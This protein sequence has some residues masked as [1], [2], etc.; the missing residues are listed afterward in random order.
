MKARDILVT[1]FPSFVARRLVQT[2]LTHEPDSTVRLLVRPDYVDAAARHLTELKVDR[3]RVKLMSGDVVALDLGLS[4]GEYLDLVAHVTDIYHIASIWYLG[5]DPKQ[6]H[7]VNVLG[8]KNVLDAAHE[9]K[10]LERLNHFST[11]LVAGDRGGVIMEDELEAGQGFRNPYEA[12]KYEAEQWMRRA[13]QTLPISVYRPTVIVGDSVTGEIDKMAGP[14]YL[15]YAIMRAPANMPIVLPGR[16]EKPLNL[17]PIDHVCEAM[18]TISRAD[19]CAGKT[20]HICD[21]NPL[22]ARKVFEMVAEQAGKPAPIGGAPIRLARLAMRLPYVERFVRGQRQFLEELYQLTI[23]NS[24]N[25]TAALAGAVPCPAL[26]DYLPN[27]V[28]HIRRSEPM[29]DI[30][31]PAI[32]DIFG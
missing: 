16:G 32:M 15:M 8:A 1:G 12:T 31:M 18:Y 10:K 30:E 13:M 21:P 26:P 11:A 4:G 7:Q 5:V 14:Y 27:L 2:I 17:V 3:S 25:T 20:F 23:Y 22:S 28:N 29:F 24:I 19:D 6:T 9:M